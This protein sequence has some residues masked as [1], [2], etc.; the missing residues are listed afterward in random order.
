M[1]KILQALDGASSKPVEGSN[2]IKRFLRVVKEADL[3]QTAEP[4]MPGQNMPPAQVNLDHIDAKTLDS[5]DGFKAAIKQAASEAGVDPET[6]QMVDKLVAA[7]PDGTVDVGKTFAKMA[8]MFSD[9]MNELVL[10]LQDLIK[11]YE[12]AMSSPEFAQFD[13]ATKQSV[14]AALAELKAELP[15]ITANAKKMSADTTSMQAQTAPA[16][17]ATNEQLGMSRFLSIV[18]EGKGPLNRLTQAESFT[19]QQYNTTPVLNVAKNS[20]PS[21][22]GKYFKQVETEML[23]TQERS[24]NRAKKIAE[25]ASKKIMERIPIG[26]GVSPEQ[27]Q[28]AIDAKQRMSQ[29]LS[30]QA[31]NNPPNGVNFGRDYLEKA[32]SGA[33]GRWKISADQAQAALDWLD[34]NPNYTPPAPAAPAPATTA[35]AADAPRGSNLKFTVLQQIKAG[36]YKGFAPKLSPEEVDAAI[37]Y[38]QKIGDLQESPIEINPS[39]PNNPTIYGHEKANPMTLKGRIMQARNQLRELADMAESNELIVWERI[40]KLAKG[41]MFMGLQQNLEQINHG[42]AELAA[43]RRKGGVSSRGIDRNIG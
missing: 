1:K 38:K 33:P 18:T 40:T 25:V 35:P 9:T 16:P 41:G 10:V 29:Q 43:K 22:V 3:N 32:V 23:E 21:L 37:A 39:E 4:P 15:K 31:A 11:T 8:A 14:K 42:I 34:K 30:A 17:Q 12:E 27:T 6:T 28:A 26:P 19:M 5:A 20:S 36:T 7:A 2:D 13:D 24:K